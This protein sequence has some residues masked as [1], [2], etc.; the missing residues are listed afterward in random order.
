M[1]WRDETQPDPEPDLRE[2]FQELA[3]TVL[4]ESGVRAA[5]QAIDHAEDWASV[6]DLTA[7]LLRH[8]RA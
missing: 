4:T 8:S 5:E 7:L 2:K 1:S 3:G 6:A